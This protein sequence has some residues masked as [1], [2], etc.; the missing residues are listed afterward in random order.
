MAK[1]GKLAKKSKG[2]A[3]G[4]NKG[5]TSDQDVAS[6]KKGKRGA[7]I[8]TKGRGKG[9]KGKS[10]SDS[11]AKEPWG[12]KAARETA[13][14]TRPRGSDE[15]K[16]NGADKR[17][18]VTDAS[19]RQ[20]RPGTPLEHKGTHCDVR[21][22]S[23]MG[24]A[25]VTMKSEE[26]RD[27]VMQLG[28]KD[29]SSEGRPQVDIKG[30]KAQMRPHID[31]VA[32]KEVKTDIFVAWGHQAEKQSPLSAATICEVFDDLVQEGGNSQALQLSAVTAS[33][34]VRSAPAQ[35]QPAAEKTKP[36][37]PKGPQPAVKLSAQPATGAGSSPMLAPMMPQQMQLAGSLS[38][39]RFPQ[40]P[41][42][43][44]QMAASMALAAQQVAASLSAA[45]LNVGAA[46]Q[47]GMPASPYNTFTPPARSGN[48]AAQSTGGTTMRAEAPSFSP[49]GDQSGLDKYAETQMWYSGNMEGGDMMDGFG[50]MP[51]PFA[52]DRR[53]MPI[54]DPKSG[55]P[56]QPTHL[57]SGQKPKAPG[58]RPLAIVDPSSGAPVGALQ[59]LDFKP[60]EGKSMTIVDPSTGGAIEKEK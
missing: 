8:D 59:A 32:S 43:L 10:G 42:N 60:A 52:A 41:A 38:S 27:K 31:K 4:S 53:P 16:K 47:C 11:D 2:A 19:M 6:S 24:C 5:P 58:R 54:V 49:V 21:K 33:P 46:G 13:S 48:C 44:Q 56:I 12:V 14:G 29:P 23:D 28:Q 40:Q 3:K 30:I 55:A 34:A 1:A 15:D 22:H 25:V 18:A 45:G 7:G 20:S 35:Q 57:N 51:G 50:Y 17:G 9:H 39:S 26:S 37:V 36:A